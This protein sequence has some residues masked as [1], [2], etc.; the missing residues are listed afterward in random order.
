MANSGKQTWVVLL[1]SGNRRN[2]IRD[3]KIVRASSESNAIATAKNRS[4]SLSG[5]RVFARAYIADPVMDLG[6]MSKAD[7]LA[8]YGEIKQSVQNTN[9]RKTV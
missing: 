8:L 3:K 2:P 4:V 9:S 7:T 1:D 5:K 6:M